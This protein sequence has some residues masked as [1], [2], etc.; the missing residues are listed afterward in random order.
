VVATGHL[1]ATAASTIVDE[2]FHPDSGFADYNIVFLNP[3]PP[4]DAMKKLLKTS[5][6]AHRVL[7]L[8]GSWASQQVCCTNPDCGTTGNTV[9][10]KVATACALHPVCAQWRPAL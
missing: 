1:T 3:S 2:L 8:Q 9:L 4:S 7:Y 6:H 10:G 5:Q